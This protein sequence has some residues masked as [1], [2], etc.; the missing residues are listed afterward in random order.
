MLE[1]HDVHR[2]FGGVKAV[3][4][5]SL[6][7]DKGRIVGLIGTNGAGKTTLFNVISGYLGADS[8]RVTFEGENLLGAP[9]YRI[10][11]RGMVRTF[12]TPTGFA[13][14]TVLENLLVFL[15]ET[16][17]GIMPALFRR[18][19]SGS[20][21]AED[22]EK[23]QAT[24]KLFGLSDKQDIWVQDLGAPEQKMLEFARAMMAEPKILLL[25]EPAAGVN[26][27]LLD[28]LTETIMRLRED[29]MTFL[30]VDHNL[31]FICRICDFIYA[32]ADGK[33]IS[34][35]GPDDVVNDPAV[36]ECYIGSAGNH[37]TAG[38]SSNQ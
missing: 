15:H 10:A 18:R 19:T 6:T 9:P 2:S 7:V 21:S 14:M 34:E 16:N 11:K 36:I 20:I 24:L 1:V 35:G 25:D 4:G 23:A 26:V 27:A 22:Y 17:T 32:M 28:S 12:Q 5:V 30:I 8:G 3:D 33:V 29:G 13:R 37:A 38:G 31:G